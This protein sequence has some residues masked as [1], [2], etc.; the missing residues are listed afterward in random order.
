MPI[1]TLLLALAVAL[2]PGAQ[3]Q[4]RELLDAA[5]TGDQATVERLLDAGLDVETADRYGSTAIAFAARGGHADIVAFL[6]ARGA[7]PNV[8]DTFYN[9]SPVARALMEQHTDV[10]LMLLQNG[11]R[12]NVQALTAALQSGDLELARAAVAAAPLPAAAASR[13]V[14]MAEETG[15][16]TLAALLRDAEVAAAGL[17]SIPFDPAT[18]PDYAGMYRNEQQGVVVEVAAGEGVLLV[19]VGD[20]DARELNP[21]GDRSFVGVDENLQLGFFGRGGAIEFARRRRCADGRRG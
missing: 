9:M 1:R 8:I 17:E 21:V 12:D 20:G 5:R 19:R 4:S 15:N 10:A 14:A 18:L 7:D 2:T 13:L 11:A 16:E 6:L 3:D